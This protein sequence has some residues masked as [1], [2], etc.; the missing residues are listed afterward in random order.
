VVYVRLTPYLNLPKKHGVP[1]EFRRLDANGQSKL[2]LKAGRVVIIQ[3]PMLTLSDHPRVS[4]YKIELAKSYGVLRQLELDLGD[5]PGR[6]RDWSGC[7][8]GVLLH[9]ASGPWF[10]REHK[11][12]AGLMLGVPDSA[13]DHWVI[14]IDLHRI[15]MFGAEPEPYQADNGASEHDIQKDN[16][17]VTPKKKSR[18]NII[19]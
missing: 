19:Q 9:G 2:L 16:V 15:A 7:L 1:F 8:L 5:I 6:I 12:L 18:K 10:T 3:E 11:S 4:D 13:Y 14:R 17:T